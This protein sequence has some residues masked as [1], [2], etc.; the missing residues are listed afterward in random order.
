MKVPLAWLR[1][2]VDVEV[3]PARSSREDLT[4]VGLAVDGIETV[5]RT[6]PSST[7]DV[8]TNR[9]DCMNVYGVAREVAVLYGL[10]LQAARPSASR[11]AGRP[12]T[13]RSTSSIE[14]PDLCPRFCARVLDVRLGPVAG[15]AAA[16]GW[17]R[18]ASGS[19]N[20]VVDLTNYVMIEMGQPTP[21]LRPRPRARRA[22]CA[23]AGR[24][25]GSG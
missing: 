20:N 2:F 7:L 18:S 17:S 6:T 11:S 22:G 12:R 19:I 14:A 15:V 10:P 23:C 5:G 13:R 3:E 25:P 24:A 4:L 21:R 8:T 16:T 1:E 9:V